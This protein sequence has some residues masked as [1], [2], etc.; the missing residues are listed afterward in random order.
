MKKVFSALILLFIIFFFPGVISAQLVINEVFPNPP[1]S[2]S[3]N[4][5][6]I[7]LFNMSDSSID[8]TGFFLEDKVGKQYIFNSITIPA[9]GF[10][11]FTKGIT[12]IALNNSDEVISLKNVSRSV[13]DEFE[14]SI[15]RE[16]KS[17]SRFPDGSG[18]FQENTDSTPDQPNV[19]VPTSTPSPLPTSE[20][21]NTLEPTYPSPTN[22][23]RPILTSEPEVLAGSLDNKDDDQSLPSFPQ[24]NENK[25][26]ESEDTSLQTDYSSNNFS[27]L[28]PYLL[29]GGGVACIS[30]GFFPL[31]KNLKKDGSI[32]T[33][34]EEI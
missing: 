1:G 27:Q 6:F 17:F 12:G 24:G 5:E 10:L 19:L 18:T 31:L 23:P 11:S 4:D 16:G 29:I 33:S 30:G 8:L 9:K 14:Y 2:Q 22:T 13:I 32:N 21:T 25:D 15:T 26:L 34:H 3:E 28:I 20:P 7:E